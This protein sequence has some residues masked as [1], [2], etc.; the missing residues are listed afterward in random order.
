MIKERF[1]IIDAPAILHRAW[2]AL[3][4]LTDK[5]GRV[6]NAVYGF[7]SFFLKLLREIKPIYLAAC[8][9]TAAPTFRHQLYKDYKATRVSQPQE[10]YDQIPLTK[11]ILKAFNIPVF[12]KHGY[13]ADDLI[14]I[15]SRQNETRNLET[16]IVT[17]DLDTLQLVDNKNKVYFLKRG[18]SEIKIYDENLVKEQYGLTPKQLID[19]KALKGDP[20]DNI[21]GVKGIGKKTA[22]ELVQRF[23][24]LEGI[25]QYLEKCSNIDSKEI[26]P[27]VKKLLIEQKDQAFIS[28]KLITI[29]KEPP[30]DLTV[31]IK[32]WPGPNN[33]EVK[34]IFKQFGFKSLLERLKKVEINPKQSSIF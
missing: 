23:G 21:P 4:K 7:I 29:L 8:F 2:H 24:S 32:P 30:K 6:I 18:I 31:E 12:E 22:F 3:P 34:E 11:E 17:G 20:S 13:E 28:K 15:L 14:G 26:R 27:E 5:K 25:Y 9:D 1:L 19:F 16:I 10:F 33:E